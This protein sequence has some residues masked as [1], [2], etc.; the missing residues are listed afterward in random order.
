MDAVSSIAG[1]KDD[2]WRYTAM[3]HAFTTN[4]LDLMQLLLDHGISAMAELLS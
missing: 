1:G 4:R 2:L 3:G